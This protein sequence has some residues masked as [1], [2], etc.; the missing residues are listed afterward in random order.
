M[1][2]SNLTQRKYHSGHE[3]VSTQYTTWVGLIVSGALI[4]FFLLMRL[5]GLHEA[6]YLRALNIL[7]LFAGIAYSLWRYSSEV[8][9][10]IYYFKGFEI[11]LR[12][13][14]FALVPF[15]IFILT[16]LVLDTAFMDYLRTYAPFGEYLGPA[17]ATGFIVIEGIIAGFIN[18]FICMQ[19]FKR[20]QPE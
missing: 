13:T 9:G 3:E 17:R 12:V 1:E 14:F 19:F 10:R 4:G 18:T 15:A 16:Y 5:F 7:F 20:N 8:N 11:G 6:F 2:T